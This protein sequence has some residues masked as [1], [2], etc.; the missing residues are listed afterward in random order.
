MQKEIMNGVRLTCV[1]A[2]KF[3]TGCISLN[4]VMPLQKKT[5]SFNA[6]LPY[7]LRRG[8]A[9]HPDMET[10]EAALDDLYGARIEPIVRKKGEM[11]CIG[12]Y[13]DFADDAF[14][15]VGAEVLEKTAELLG[16]VLLAPST[17]AGRLRRDYVETERTNLLSDLRA[18]IN[19]KRAYARRRLVELMCAGE[20]YGISKLGTVADAKKITAASLTKHY[21]EIIASAQIEI[22]YCGSASPERVERAMKS[23]LA[24]LPRR[25][26]VTPAST[27]ILPEPKGA[28]RFFREN[29]DV[30]QAKLVMGYRLGEPIL[31]GKHAE[32]M[33][34]NAVFGGAVTSKLFMNVRE[35]LSLCYYATSGL[36]RY[37][38]LMFVS[39][40]I[41]ADKLDETVAEIKAQLDAVRRGDI[42]DWELD[43]AR[44]AVVTALTSA[45]DSQLGLEA[46]SLD[47]TLLGITISPE[48]LAAL[49]DL[50]SKEDVIKAANAVKLDSVYFLAGEAED[51]Q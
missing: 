38:G 47:F 15:G 12:F 7:V 40:G 49:A 14:V 28:E 42:E 8:T 3:K 20:S 41:D 6:L 9:R 1:T 29:M 44:K 10:L 16:E 45:T 26:S 23:A 27:E 46:L 5:A 34:M 13:A 43:G 2:Y 35:K 19:D 22:F 51:A 36:D 17:K 50:V 11:Q 33:V 30:T 24:T 37:K 48:E 32:L 39:A 4:L 21:R 31:A 25:E 18:E